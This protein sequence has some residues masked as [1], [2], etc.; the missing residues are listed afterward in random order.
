MP[1]HALASTLVGIVL[2][3]RPATPECVGSW[4]LVGAGDSCEGFEPGD[5]Y[6]GYLR[7]PCCDTYP[8][9]HY[10]CALEIGRLEPVPADVAEELDGRRATEDDT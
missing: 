4:H 8:P 10:A 6:R 3:A 1:R 7:K 5:V 9:E 2:I